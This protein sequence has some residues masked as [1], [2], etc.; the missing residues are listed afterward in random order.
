MPIFAKQSKYSQLLNSLL[1]TL[2]LT[3]AFKPK[4][5]RSIIHGCTTNSYAYLEK[6]RQRGYLRTKNE[7]MYLTAKAKGIVTGQQ[8]AIISQRKNGSKQKFHEL[9]LARSLFLCL[10]NLD[11]RTI[12]LIKKQKQH[13]SGLIPDALI[14]TRNR[15]IF[16]EIDTGS[17][18]IQTINNKIEAYQMHGKEKTVIY[19]T[20]LSKNFN[21]FRHH[22]TTHFLYLQSST[23]LEDILTLP[24]KKQQLNTE[25]NVKYSDYQSLNSEDKGGEDGDL[26]LERQQLLQMLNQH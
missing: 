2:H 26:D 16:L 3:R 17:E 4:S 10:L 12:E 24:I 7:L 9:M 25:S 5:V 19:F 21:H 18:G 14:T 11:H 15:D 23:I 8:F 22:P 13:E 6:L 20:N 1:I